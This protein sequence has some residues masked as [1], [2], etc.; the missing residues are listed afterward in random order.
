MGAAVMEWQTRNIGHP[1]IALV[2]PGTMDAFEA[3]WRERAG[4]PGVEL[5]AHAPA[6]RTYSRCTILG[7]ELVPDMTVDDGVIA[8][9]GPQWRFMG[10]IK[11]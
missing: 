2:S 7:I 6:I 5:T 1:P 11:I 3:D 10:A 9:V 8:F 4:M